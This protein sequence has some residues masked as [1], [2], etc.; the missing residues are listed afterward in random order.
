MIYGFRGDA[1]NL[2]GS[3]LPNLGGETTLPI[4][5]SDSASVT[6]TSQCDWLGQSQ[7]EQIL[8]S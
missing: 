1:L 5:E 4:S 2:G 8:T 6:D 7:A 3:L